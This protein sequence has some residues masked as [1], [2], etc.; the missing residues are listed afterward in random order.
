MAKEEIEEE[1]EEESEEIQNAIEDNIQE[2]SDNFRRS[3][4][5][6][7]IPVL[8]ESNFENLEQEIEES[9]IEETN[10]DDSGFD[11]KSGGGFYEDSNDAY[12]LN[13]NLSENYG[14]GGMG[15]YNTQ[16]TNFISGEEKTGFN[17]PRSSYES[18]EDR[19]KKE[20]KEKFF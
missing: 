10:Q 20:E 16:E 2:T 17:N 13:R 14:G 19:R 8:S 11:Y 12:D 15:D 5:D 4:V 6:K 18:E 3:V 9:I 7:I 1:I